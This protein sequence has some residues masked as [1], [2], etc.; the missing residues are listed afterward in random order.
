[1]TIATDRTMVARVER[2]LALADAETIETG[3]HRYDIGQQMVARHAQL[4]GR[5]VEHAAAEMSHL[6]PR[7]RWENNVKAAELFARTGEKRQGIMSG[8]FDRAVRAS[9]SDAPLASF[10]PKAHKTRALAANLA[11]DL[12]EVTVDVWIA[13]AMKVSETELKRVGVYA[14]IAKAFRKV[15]ARHNLE[16]AQLQAIVWIVERG[17]AV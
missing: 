7:E 11:G 13:R 14:R 15:A 1:M 6:S 8:P 5:T 4:S 16:P 17:S 9:V 10:G 3:R 2:K 12:T